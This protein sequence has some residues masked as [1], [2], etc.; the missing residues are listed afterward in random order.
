MSST[1][2]HTPDDEVD[3][4]ALNRESAE[5]DTAE[6]PGNQMA[7]RVYMEEMIKSAEA[8]WDANE[9]GTFDTELHKAMKRLPELPDVPAND[10]LRERLWEL[11]SAL[12]SYFL[13]LAS[14]VMNMEPPDGKKAATLLWARQSLDEA[15]TLLKKCPETGEFT[16]L[17]G[18]QSV[19]R[20]RLNAADI[21]HLTLAKIAGSLN[22]H[23]AIPELF[24]VELKRILSETQSADERLKILEKQMRTDAKLIAELQE[25]L[26][27]QEPRS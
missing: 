1:A 10:H 12:I 4:G 23:R 24:Q 15:E 2:E 16:A 14:D 5:G 7:V 9:I 3:L 17:R 20:S 6:L 11:Q 21:S 22:L 18:R 13:A 19:L 27:R 26:N 8:A 25:R